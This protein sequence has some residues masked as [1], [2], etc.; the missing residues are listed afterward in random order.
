MGGD[1]EFWVMMTFGQKWRYKWLKWTNVERSMSLATISDAHRLIWYRNPKV[2]SRTI[3]AALWDI[4]P[5]LTEF[6]G[7]TRLPLAMRRDYFSFAIV[8]N[9][10]DRAVSLWRQKVLSTPEHGS[11]IWKLSSA[12]I[13]KLRD[14]DA[15]L[16][17]LERQDL[18][19]GEAHVRKQD[20][21]VPSEVNYVGKMENLAEDW[22]NVLAKSGI[23]A[24][25]QLQHKNETKGN[26]AEALTEV[27][28]ARI[29]QLY[30]ADVLRFY[31]ELLVE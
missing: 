3:S 12:Q 2:A 25:S 13:A 10:V 21:F 26:R 1:A 20:A 15:F 6:P 17:W 23:A 16:D 8:R 30:R 5:N 11:R 29:I 27:Q 7:P 31:P 18:N 14:F 24:S 4:D 9:P 22:A 19:R 28:R